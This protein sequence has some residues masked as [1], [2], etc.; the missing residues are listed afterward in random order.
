ML[1]LRSHTSSSTLPHP[2][3]QLAGGVF[4]GHAAAHAACPPRLCCPAGGGDQPAQR[5]GSGAWQPGTQGEAL[6]AAGCKHYAHVQCWAWCTACTLHGGQLLM[7]VLA[8]HRSRTAVVH[9]CCTPLLRTA[10]L[11]RRTPT[12]SACMSWSDSAR[13]TRQVAGSTLCRAAMWP[14][15]G[16]P[17]CGLQC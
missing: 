8:A 11:G 3:S 13:S 2:N 14:C 5:C 10:V 1:L 17:A 15:C 9:Y 12:T 7:R 4:A 6:W 16:G